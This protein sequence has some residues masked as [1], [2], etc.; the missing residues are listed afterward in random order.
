MFNPHHAHI[1]ICEEALLWCNDPF[2]ILSILTV[3]KSRTR[4]R[5]RDVKKHLPHVCPL[6]MWL[7][8]LV[9]LSMDLEKREIGILVL[10]S[11]MF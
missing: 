11:K 2:S 9:W 4:L 5:R 10:T 8:S 3:V 1:N 6:N 7:C